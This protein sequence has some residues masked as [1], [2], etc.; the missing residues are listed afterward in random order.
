M[1]R[2]KDMTV[3]S[4]FRLIIL[5][6]LPI[7]A[8]NLLQQLYSLVD[9]LVVGQV[10]G[11]TA[12][13]AVSSS[14]W[15]DWM[16]L[17]LAMG[18]AQGFAIQI[19]Q[20]FGAGDMAAMH[21]AEGQSILLSV[22]SVVLVGVLAQAL[23]SPVL[24]LMQTPDETRPLT[25]L[26]LRIVFGGLPLVMLYNLSAGFLRSVGDS[27][28]P[29][30][31]VVSSTVLN[32]ALDVLFVQTLRWSVA[33]VGAATVT[34]QGL[35]ALICTVALCRLPVMRITRADLA[36]DRAMAV[37]L[38]KLGLPMSFQNG[39]ISVGGLV[40]QGV[41]N[42]FG[43]IFMAGYSA[44]SRLQGLIELAGVSLSS[45]MGSFAGQNLGAGKLDRVRRGQR[46]SILISV[47][48][49]VAIGAVM[50]AFGRPLLSLFIDKEPNPADPALL[51]LGLPYAEIVRQVLDTGYNFLCVMSAGLFTLYLLFVYRSTLQGIGDTVVPMI[52]GFV[53]LVMR[54][55]CVL[56]LPMLIGEWGVYAAEI[57]AWAGAAVLLA[58]GY[59]R[60][61]RLL[62][63]GRFRAN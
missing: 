19:A 29:L 6:S 4:P 42:G 41:V 21:R 44:A 25:E 24:T 33:G 31:A 16:V 52:S 13:A 35:S 48:M 2:T 28:T 56:L 58:W 15:L 61:M 46:Q 45:A 36:P 26:Y 47:G 8:G 43:Y 34:S 51:T 1:A 59:Y 9:T 62:E 37:R 32:I 27:R 50:I 55:G 54:V 14:G 22:A 63:S 53:E 38:L 20:S 57:A 12:L 17:S 11:V 7:V 39:I 23:L 3:G 49:A 60:R 40:L 10:E 30:I 18:L 5:F